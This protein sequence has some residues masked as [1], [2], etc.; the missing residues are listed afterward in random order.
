MHRDQALRRIMS[1]AARIRSF[2]V[3]ALYLFGSV[4]RE[5]AGAE[6]DV[7]VFV[8][9]DDRLDLFALAG[10]RQHLSDLLGRSV[11]VGTRAGLHPALRERIESE[12]IRVF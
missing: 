6:S 8:D 4:A 9:D 5:A 12:A 11:D 1:D 2:G 7:D 10:L 3:A